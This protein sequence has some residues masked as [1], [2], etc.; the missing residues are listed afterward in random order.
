MKPEFI[1]PQYIDST[2]ISCFRSCPQKFA[3]E[4]CYG[5]RPAAIS[6]DLH[7]GACFATALE[8]TYEAVWVEGLDLDAALQRSYR[9]FADAWGD[10][11]PLS[12]TPKTFDRVW[13]AV[14]TYF[15]V[16]P[17]FTDPVQPFIINGRPALEFS[18]AIPL[19]SK[20]FPLH[21]SG[22]PF[23]YSGRFD[24]LGTMHGRPVGRDEKTTKSIGADWS[25]QWDL[26]SQFIGYTWAAR[27]SGIEALDTIVV[28]GIG[29]LKT[30]ISTAEAVKQYSDSLR[31]RWFDQLRRDLWRLRRMH[32]EDH[33]DFNL[34]DA[35]SIY[36]GCSF[37]LPCTSPTPENWFGQYTTRRWNPLQKN[38]I[39]ATT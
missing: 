32:D 9:R 35:C 36:G 33:F 22:E 12:D 13:E 34:A 37:K 1:L 3:L 14:E 23:V 27:Q 39:E 4:F 25:S 17:P 21:P 18:F 15:S 6:V 19:E 5:L 31:E 26:R 24:M 2:M 38:P 7:A 30:K 11:T 20:G 10:F 29:I 16:W 8:A 28:R